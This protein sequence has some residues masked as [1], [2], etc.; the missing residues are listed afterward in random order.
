[1]TTFPIIRLETIPLNPFEYVVLE[2]CF[3]PELGITV[4]AGAYTNLTT[5]P[6]I[7]W[8]I[9]PPHGAT[10]EPSIVHD[11]LIRSG[12]SKN[13]ADRCFLYLLLQAVPE[14]QAIAMFLAIRIFKKI[15]NRIEK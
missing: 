10:K 4:T 11:Y 7:F 13:Y 6:R 5:V 3:V 1:M 9:I 15:R 14:W 2:D 12:Q 8:S